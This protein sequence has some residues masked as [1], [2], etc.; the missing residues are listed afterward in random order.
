MLVDKTKTV[1]NYYELSGDL[2]IFKDGIYPNDKDFNLKL[3]SYL[4]NN[5]LTNIKTV[6]TYISS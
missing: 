3:F 6:G 2:K 1:D 4:Q 5:S